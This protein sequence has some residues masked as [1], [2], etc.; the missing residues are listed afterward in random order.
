M[1]SARAILTPPV[2]DRPQVL[3]ALELPRDWLEKL[4]ER[5]SHGL[6]RVIDKHIRYVTLEDFILESALLAYELVL[7]FVIVYAIVTFGACKYIKKF[8][9]KHK[10]NC[11]K[12]I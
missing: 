4:A 9:W 11:R 5:L 3:Q 8:L 10:V 1:I 6:A 12:R 7:L 2:S